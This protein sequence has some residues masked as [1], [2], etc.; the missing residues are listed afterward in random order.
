MGEVCSISVVLCIYQVLGALTNP[1]LEH[2]ITTV[3]M[4]KKN[5]LEAKCAH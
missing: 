3:I 5:Y 4:G 1:S 2:E